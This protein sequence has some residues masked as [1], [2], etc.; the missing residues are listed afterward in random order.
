[1]KKCAQ[2]NPSADGVSKFLR[3]V[4]EKINL[5]RFFSDFSQK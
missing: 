5:N 3:F 4:Y 2:N 1:M